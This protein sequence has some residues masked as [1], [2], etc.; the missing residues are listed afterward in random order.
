MVKHN[1]E[2][3]GRPPLMAPSCYC[4]IP[5]DVFEDGEHYTDEFVEKHYKRCMENFDL[6]MQYFDGLNYDDF[7]KHLLSVVKKN[8]LVEITDLAEVDG[9]TGIYIM[10]LDRYKQ[11]YVGLSDSIK[12]RI[13]S[14]W[15]TKK[16]FGHL[17]YGTVETS[18]LSIDSFGALDT[19]R[20]FYKELKWHQN[21]HEYEEKIVFQFRPE[22]RL[23]R[24]AGGLNRDDMDKTCRNL[25]LT[26]TRQNRK[27]K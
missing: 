2:L 1:I 20:I 25:A 15:S 13:L 4:E 17:V 27:L 8:K 9:K 12:S 10:V 6:N 3:C 19:T 14:H 18:I 11:V 16:D 21:M 7:N 26:A 24:V 5:N 23:N 22:Y